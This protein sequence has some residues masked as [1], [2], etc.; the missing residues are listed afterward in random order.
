M[1]N[2]SV[3]SL[4]VIFRQCPGR[5]F[6][7]FSHLPVSTSLVRLGGARPQG[8][9]HRAQS[10]RKFYDEQLR[11]GPNDPTNAPGQTTRR[12]DPSCVSAAGNKVPGSPA[13]IVRIWFGAFK[14]TP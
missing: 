7:I 4:S 12:S 3:T 11:I 6:A 5:P 2:A 8:A 10:S 13:I 9:R 14:I 1:P